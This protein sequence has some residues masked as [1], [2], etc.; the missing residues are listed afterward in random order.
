MILGFYIK[1]HKTISITLS[2]FEYCEYSNIKFDNV[3][4]YI[5]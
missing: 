1:A 5:T 2:I 3:P 4:K